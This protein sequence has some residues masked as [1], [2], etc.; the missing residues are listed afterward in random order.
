MNA[1]IPAAMAR[2]LMGS[3]VART[4]ATAATPPRPKWSS[5][6]SYV[7]GHADRQSISRDTELTLRD[8]YSEV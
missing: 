4:P 3:M 2:R 5:G 8:K 7:H 6:L 1:V